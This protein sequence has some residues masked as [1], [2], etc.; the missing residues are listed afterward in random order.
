[1]TEN[2]GSLK[3]SVLGSDAA[4]RPD[5]QSE[6]VVVGDLTN[7]GAVNAVFD[8]GHGREDGID[9]DHADRLVLALVLIASGKTT[10]DTNFKFTIELHFFV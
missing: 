3:Q 4:I 9:R 2:R 1:M 6:L 5:I 8:A 10:P 7:P